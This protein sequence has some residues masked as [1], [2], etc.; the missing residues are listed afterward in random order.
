MM[1]VETLSG[2]DYLFILLIIVLGFALVS[3]MTLGFGIGAS[4]DSV[5]Y[6]GSAYNFAQGKG[7]SVAVTSFSDKGISVPYLQW[8]PLYPL[9]ISPLIYI[10]LNPLLAAKLISALFLSASASLIFLI[11]RKLT[12]PQFAYISPILCLSL[13][14]LIKVAVFAWSEIPYLF[15]SVLAL[16]FLIAFVDKYKG[17]KETFASNRTQGSGNFCFKKDSR[18]K[19]YQN[20]KVSFKANLFLAGTFVALA[21]TTRY[22]GFTLYLAGLIII[23]FVRGSYKDKIKRILIFTLPVVILMIPWL[24]RNMTITGYPLDITRD[25]STTHLL[26]KILENSE[27]LIKTIFS[28]LHLVRLSKYISYYPFLSITLSGLIIII[29]TALVNRYLSTEIKEVLSDNIVLIVYLLVYYLVIVVLRAVIYFDEIGTR[30]ISPTYPFLIPLVISIFS[31]LYNRFG[32]PVKI[33]VLSAVAILLVINIYNIDKYYTAT[34]DGIGYSSERWRKDEGIEW[35][36][37]SDIKPDT[38]VYSDRADA[39]HLLLHTPTKYTPPLREIRAFF[40]EKPPKYEDAYIIGFKEGCREPLL[41]DDELKEGNKKYKSLLLIRDFPN[42]SIW[43]W[44]TNK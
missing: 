10:G 24:Y 15:F 13:L 30:L 43:K 3:V 21:I 33:A 14:P 16:L 18:L 38:I 23:I 27:L 6:L 41:S 8:P 26:R 22:I 5:Y 11:T 1:R 19:S 39:V 4:P 37:K 20:K 35:L 25:I 44:D 36:R 9:M 7:L 28:D 40:R 31:C 12:D 29:L 32:I 17:V 34:R 42:S 2:D